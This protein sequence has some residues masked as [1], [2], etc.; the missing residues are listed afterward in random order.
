MAG[1]Y[2]PTTPTIRRRRPCSQVA[3]GVTGS[4]RRYLPHCGPGRMLRHCTKPRKEGARPGSLAWERGLPGSQAP[5]H[6][7]NLKSPHV[8]LAVALAGAGVSCTRCLSPVPPA[9]H[10]LGLEISGQGKVGVGT[11]RQT[12][13]KAGRRGLKID[14][15]LGSRGCNSMTDLHNRDPRTDGPMLLFGFWRIGWME[16]THFNLSRHARLNLVGC[17]FSTRCAQDKF[18]EP[19]FRVWQLCLTVASGSSGVGCLLTRPKGRAN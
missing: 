15:C 3:P 12:D 16:Q 1:R 18:F 8:A 14:T 19:R 9:A 7:P 11:G 5:G 4:G 17:P 2:L 6:R 13:R 10:P